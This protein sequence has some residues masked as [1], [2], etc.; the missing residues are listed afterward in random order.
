MESAPTMDDDGF[1][2]VAQ[3][4][5]VVQFVCN[6]SGE[7]APFFLWSKNREIIST[8]NSRSVYTVNC[9]LF[10]FYLKKICINV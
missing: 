6:A 5:E 8:K 4:G 9:N 3:E 2:K 1:E 10:I 7:P